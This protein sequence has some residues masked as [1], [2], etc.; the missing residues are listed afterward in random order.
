MDQ[1]SVTQPPTDDWL[2]QLGELPFS[3][4]VE[5]L[6]RHFLGTPHVDDPFGEGEAG[7][8]DRQPI[9]RFDAFDCVSYAE[10]VLALAVG[11]SL[12]R[13][14]ELVALMRYQ[15]G[16]VAFE[17]RCHWIAGQWVPH[18]LAAG[19]LTNHL[20]SSPDETLRSFECTIDWAE[21]YGALPLERVR[22]PDVSPEERLR[23]WEELRQFGRGCGYLRVEQSFFPFSRLFCPTPE[24]AGPRTRP[25]GSEFLNVGLLESLPPVAVVVFLGRTAEHVAIALPRGGAGP[26][27]HAADGRPPR[28][29]E[30]DLLGALAFRHRFTSHVGFRVFG[31]NPNWN[32]GMAG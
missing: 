18:N 14:A 24:Q 23:V 17:D 12:R 25:Y 5:A 6:C 21:W 27:Y 15:S 9:V 31:V 28:V 13:A 16:C 7:R 3:Q 2:R 30:Q 11:L 20:P 8:F 10:T 26:L 1:P 22:R 19:L 29:Y 32:G 4:R